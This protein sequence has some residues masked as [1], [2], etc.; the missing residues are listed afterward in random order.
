[1]PSRNE[2]LAYNKDEN[3]IGKDIGADALIYQDLDDLKS[4][5]IKEN[6]LLQNFDCSCFDGQ[7]VTSDIDEIYLN[8]I[9]SIRSDTEH[10][11]K[12]NSSNQ[13][14]LNLLNFPSENEQEHA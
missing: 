5:I 14:D 9:E 7:Y 2:L 10:N 11:K 13:L 12:S 8:K 3:E 1:M 4:T 6:K